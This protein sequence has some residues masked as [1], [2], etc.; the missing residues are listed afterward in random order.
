MRYNMN[1]PPEIS[2]L[3]LAPRQ[4]E[5]LGAPQ[6]QGA[7]VLRCGEALAPCQ[8]ATMRE[9]GEGIS[10]GVYLQAVGET[11]VLTIEHIY[12]WSDG[13]PDGLDTLGGGC[14]G[15][16]RDEADLTDDNSGSR[17][18]HEVT[19]DVEEGRGVVLSDEQGNGL[20]KVLKLASTRPVRYF[21]VKVVVIDQ[22][23]CA[24]GANDEATSSSAG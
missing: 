15:G 21:V 11:E 8:G 23:Y 18:V 22:D 17:R 19:I 7:G 16:I 13:V 4:P 24:D 6:G 10:S 9:A 5:V 14:G 3:G 2:F 20:C 12:A 1:E